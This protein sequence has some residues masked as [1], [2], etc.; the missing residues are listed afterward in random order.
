[1]TVYRKWVQLLKKQTKKKT[2]TQSKDN[3]N[4]LKTIKEI[5]FIIIILPKEKSPDLISLEKYIKH[6]RKNEQHFYTLL[7]RK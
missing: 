1:M 5:E 6:L 4:C 7:S 2:T 3:L